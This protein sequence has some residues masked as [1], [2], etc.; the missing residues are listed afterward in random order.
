MMN[1]AVPI[2]SA[3]INKVVQDL[4]PDMWMENTYA[5]EVAVAPG[6]SWRDFVAKRGSHRA[7]VI[8]DPMIG[9]PQTTT[10][11]TW[12]ER[13]QPISKGLLSDPIFESCR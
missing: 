11:R 3:S 4:T 2:N 10:L 12:L 8:R 13:S 6:T 1:K 7:E 5:V 9:P